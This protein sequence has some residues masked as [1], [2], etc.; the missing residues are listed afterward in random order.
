MRTRREIND[1]PST[2]G[3]KMCK[4]LGEMQTYLLEEYLQCNYKKKS[5]QDFH[6]ECSSLAPISS[7]FNEDLVF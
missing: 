6:E 5:L 7:N 3:D 1:T 2:T 4:N